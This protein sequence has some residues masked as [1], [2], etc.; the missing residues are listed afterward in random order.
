MDS[1]Q[2]SHLAVPLPSPAWAGG[3]MLGIMGMLKVMRR[4]RAII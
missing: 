3:A 1:S 2:P 4:K